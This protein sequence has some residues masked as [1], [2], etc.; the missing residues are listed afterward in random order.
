MRGHLPRPRGSGTEENDVLSRSSTNKRKISSQN[1]LASCG[2]F[3]VR[4]RTIKNL[5]YPARAPR[6]PPPENFSIIDNEMKFSS[7]GGANENGIAP[8]LPGRGFLRTVDEPKLRPVAPPGSR[9]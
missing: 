6:I 3:S 5:F 4:V 8:S 9:R 2:R 1:I 7:V